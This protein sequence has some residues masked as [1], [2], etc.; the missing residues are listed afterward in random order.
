MIRNSYISATKNTYANAISSVGHHQPQPGQAGRVQVFVQVILEQL[1]KQMRQV[2]VEWVRVH[3]R[4]A[5]V[6][7]HQRFG[8]EE[9]DV[10]FEPHSHHR[11]VVDNH[12]NAL[13]V[14]IDRQQVE[15]GRNERI[16]LRQMK[17]AIQVR[18]GPLL[19]VERKSK[20][21]NK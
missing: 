9:F 15:I 10:L 11:G 21:F 20:I 12:R 13:D 7:I 3:D 16:P 8:L 19:Q 1:H 17:I 5:K 18:F 6:Q 14:R 4:T 2:A